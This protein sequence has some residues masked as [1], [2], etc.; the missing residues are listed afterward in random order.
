MNIKFRIVHFVGLVSLALGST[1]TI[2]QDYWVLGSFEVERNAQNEAARLRQETGLEIEVAGY[3]LGNRV[4]N[5]VVLAKKPESTHQEIA[6]STGVMPWTLY[7]GVTIVPRREVAT[8][9][10]SRASK[11]DTGYIMPERENP[12]TEPETKV[13]YKTVDVD[14]SPPGK[15]ESLVEY[16]ISKANPKERELF[17]SDDMLGRV[18]S[19]SIDG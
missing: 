6:S 17:C 19:A 10:R 5:R 7:E 2:A 1:V 11:A 14:I 18:L 12:R 8:L 16:C 13:V 3:V 4:Y 15:K 9:S